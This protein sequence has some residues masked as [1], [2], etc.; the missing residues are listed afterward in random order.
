MASK[1]M[2]EMKEKIHAMKIVTVVKL[3]YAKDAAPLAK[4]LV[5]LGIPC[6]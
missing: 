1:L 5:E 3:N 2:E 6:S 4:A